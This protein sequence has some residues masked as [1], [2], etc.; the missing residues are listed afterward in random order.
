M[1]KPCQHMAA[2][3]TDVPV[4]RVYLD[5]VEKGQDLCEPCIAYAEQ[6]GMHPVADRRAAPR[7]PVWRQRDLSRDLTQRYGS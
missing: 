1:T 7:I 2:A 6:V 4:R 3:C 5:N